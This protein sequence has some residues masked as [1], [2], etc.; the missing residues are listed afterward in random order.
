SS[1]LALP[2]SAAEPQRCHAVFSS[3]LGTRTSAGSPIYDWLCDFTSTPTYTAV[4]GSPADRAD[5]LI[6]RASD[7]RSGSSTIKPIARGHWV[8]NDLVWESLDGFGTRTW[9]SPEP[10]YWIDQPGPSWMD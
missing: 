7:W 6:Y 1:V 10:G 8:G 2:A 9:S 5:S 3:D 4:A